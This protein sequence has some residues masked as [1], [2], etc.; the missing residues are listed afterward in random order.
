MKRAAV[1]LDGKAFHRLPDTWMVA[2]ER[3]KKAVHGRPL[4]GGG[5]SDFPRLS[6]DSKRFKRE[7]KKPP[8]HSATRNDRP[9][10]GTAS[11]SLIS[12]MRDDLSSGLGGKRETKNDES[13]SG[14]ASF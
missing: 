6:A 3:N 12:R 13:R 14:V 8:V 9:T 1:S 5:S 4:E 2:T 10:K 7:M 11:T